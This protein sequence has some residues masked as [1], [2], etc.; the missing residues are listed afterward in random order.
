M[1]LMETNKIADTDREVAELISDELERQ[2]TTIELIASENIVSEAVMAA[3]GTVLTNK[4]AE[5]KPGKRF[6]NGCEVVDKIEALAQE[7]A[8]KLFNMPHVNVG[9]ISLCIETR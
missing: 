1:M 6:Y 3:A 7:R 5:G 8:K 9:G 2:R 4:Y